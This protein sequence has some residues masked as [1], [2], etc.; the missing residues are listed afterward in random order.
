MSRFSEQW[1]EKIIKI[2]RK[3]AQ[4]FQDP[5]VTMVSKKWK[6]PFLVLV[7]CML[8]LRTKDETTI[9]AAE[10]LFRLGT[11]PAKIHALT[12]QQIERAIYPVGF[13]H[14]KARNIKSTC[15]D[16]LFRFQGKVPDSLDQ[17]LTLKGVG[18]K[19]AN[20]VLTEG[21]GKLGI[22]VDTH[23]HRIS[24]RLGYITTK[25]PEQTEWALRK[26]LPKK[27]WIEY[28]VLLVIWGQNVCRPVSPKCS[29]CAVQAL[30][31]Q[32]NVT[33]RR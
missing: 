16:L 10:R 26:K 14:T 31:L 2:F 28:N 15:S 1:I 30:C 13:Y 19:T 20:L 11:T 4:E 8:S 12:I 22:C 32:K 25:T 9:P 27:F 7:S 29:Q 17:L 18:R 24:N 33:T 3:A 23:V 21:F 6:N 5:S